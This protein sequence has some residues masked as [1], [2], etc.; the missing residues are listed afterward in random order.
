MRKTQLIDRFIDQ[1]TRLDERVHMGFADV[2]FDELTHRPEPASWSAAECLGHIVITFER[3]V[4]ALEK[5]FERPIAQTEDIDVKKGFLGNWFAQQMDPERGK[6]MRTFS[7][8]EPVDVGPDVLDRYHAYHD[9][10]LDYVRRSPDVDWTKMMVTSPVNKF[11]R[12]R[13]GDAY[14]IFLHHDERHV[15]QAER[16]LEAVLP[17]D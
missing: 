13:L 12:F 6:R 9:T 14:T 11:V 17:S 16:A 1:A 15:L 3:Y 4:P 10:L 8:F 2:P 7:V 5:I